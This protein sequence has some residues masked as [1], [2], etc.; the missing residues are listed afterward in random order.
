MKRIAS[1]CIICS[2]TDIRY[3][4]VVELSDSNVVQ[5]IFPLNENQSE[6][7]NTLF[8]DGII[9]LPVLSLI[10]SGFQWTDQLEPEYQLI[11]LSGNSINATHFSSNKKI[12]ID[13][14]TTDIT[15]I[16]NLISDNYVFFQQFSFSDIITACTSTP[17]L[18]LNK[19]HELKPGITTQLILWE[20]VDFSVKKLS[21]YSKIR[22]I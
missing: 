22:V 15:T 2:P 1:Q 19:T 20:K 18:F 16:C 5:R 8:F 13:L 7:A 9:S 6:P 14:G 12:I 21:K 11:S 10:E 4:S 17:A 3:N